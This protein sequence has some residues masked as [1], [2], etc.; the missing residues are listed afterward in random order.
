MG[1]ARQN[2]LAQPSQNLIN[3]TQLDQNMQIPGVTEQELNNVAGIINGFA[4]QFQGGA[5]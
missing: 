2:G 1:Q 4:N 5:Q 3:G